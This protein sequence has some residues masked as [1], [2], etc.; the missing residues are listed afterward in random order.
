MT[1]SG[2]AFLSLM[3]NLLRVIYFKIVMG[4]ILEFNFS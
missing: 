2:K 3:E 1:S 4:D